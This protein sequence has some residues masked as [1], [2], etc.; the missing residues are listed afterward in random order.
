VSL[1]GRTAL[2]TGAARGIGLAIAQRLAAD[3][4]RVAVLDLDR[5]GAEAAAKR[6]GPEALPLVADVTRSAEV[7]RA[8]GEVVARWQ[9]L[10][11]LVN[12]AGITGRSFP[13]WEL[14]DDD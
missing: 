9:R 10:D 2:V 5:P 11:V 14:S 6:L 1:Q 8:V 7:E 12:N 4:A 13:L 3:G